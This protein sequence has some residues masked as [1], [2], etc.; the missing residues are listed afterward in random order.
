MNWIMNGMYKRR[1]LVTGAAGYLGSKI[2]LQLRDK[3]Y[4]V[5]A[6]CRNI[7]E[8]IQST[9]KNITLIQAD[10]TDSSSYDKLESISD[11]DTI[12]HTVSLDHHQSQELSILDVN[13]INILPTWK[14]LNRF[15]QKKITK[16]IYLST[17]QVLGN[18]PKGSIKENSVPNPKNTYAL[19]HLMCENMLNYY[20]QTSETACINVR[21]SNGYGPPTFKNNNCWWLLI[22]DLCKMAYY[23][24]KIILKSDG[25]AEKD[26][27]HISDTA[28]AI[29]L[30]IKQ[31]HKNKINIFNISSGIA[32]KLLTVAHIIQ[33]IFASKFNVDIP[34]Y[35]NKSELSLTTPLTNPNYII[36][37]DRIKDL[38]YWSPM[39]IE[40]G[41]ETL[42][43]YFESIEKKLNEPIG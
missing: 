28:K 13:R 1:V 33:R 39:S 10:L 42:F 41:I 25:T 34:V 37:H 11:I 6:V 36:N 7:T 14:L 31:D 2:C 5:V 3:E 19:T 20:N 21:L 9:F 35:Y 15:T 43:D 24:K 27:V 30:L 32:Y 16:F 29:E 12:I 22:N 18:L 26:F 8:E 38:G 40:D 17:I 4:S 23:D